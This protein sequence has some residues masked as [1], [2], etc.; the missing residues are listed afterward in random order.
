MFSRILRNINVLNVLLL[1]AILGFV[2]YLLFPLVDHPV[3]YTSPVDNVT[4]KNKKASADQ[5]EETGP[6]P[7]G[8]N[9]LEFTVIAEQNLFHPDR[10]IPPEKKAEAPLPMPEF[11]LYGTLITG[12]FMVAYLEDKKATPVSTPGRGKR[13]TALKKGELMSGFLLKEIQADRVMMNRG[14]ETLVVYLNDSQNPKAREGMADAAKPGVKAPPGPG[15]VSRPTPSAS[16]AEAKAA[17]VVPPAA[18]RPAPPTEPSPATAAAASPPGNGSSGT[19]GSGGFTPSRP[20]YRP[21]PSTPSPGPYPA[22]SPSPSPG[23]YP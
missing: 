19:G 8:T 15:G 1:A 17:P 2:F 20:R 16:A 12:D 11:I 13:Q 7:P 9:P 14:E 23:P 3:V 18:T 21:M 4:T 5:G 6:P 22:P 10:K